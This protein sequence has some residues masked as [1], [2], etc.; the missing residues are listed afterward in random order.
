VG[1]HSLEL[2][3]VH[4]ILRGGAD[5]LLDVAIFGQATEDELVDK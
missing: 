4:R 2:A 3:P 1:I 5:L